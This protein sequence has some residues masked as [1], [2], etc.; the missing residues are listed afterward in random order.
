ML[1]EANIIVAFPRADDAGNIRNILVRNGIGVSAVVT[2]GRGAL[3]AADGLE[4]GIIISSYKH[5]D[6]PYFEIYENM[7]K[8]FELL[9]VASWQRLA[10]CDIP[11]IVKLPMPFIVSDLIGTIDMM[12]GAVH[13]R[14]DGHL[15]RSRTAEEEKTLGTAKR[16]LMERN[17]LTEDEAHKYIQ[18]CSMDSGTGLIE[19][20]QMILSMYDSLGL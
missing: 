12:S 13:R 5:K 18:K 8:G 7:P 6:M 11:D 1:M 4:G 9:L 15:K 2:S 16:V 20:A 19:S 3:A 10:E 17:G 14:R